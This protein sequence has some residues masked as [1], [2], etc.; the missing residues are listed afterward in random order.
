MK[1][2][3]DKKRIEFQGEDGQT[4]SIYWDNRGEPYRQGLTFC[5]KENYDTLAYVFLEAQELRAVRDLLN[6]LYS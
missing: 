3:L 5:L 1:V 2:D 4:L 6:R